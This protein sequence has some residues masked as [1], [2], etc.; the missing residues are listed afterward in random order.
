MEVGALSTG[1]R[2][3]VPVSC[4]GQQAWS[5]MEECGDALTNVPEKSILTEEEFDT[6]KAEATAKNEAVLLQL[7]SEAC[8]RCPAFSTAISE[9]KDTH[10]FRWVYGDAHATDTELPEL[11]SVTQLPA[12]I[13]Y[14]PGAIEPLVVPN[15]SPDQLTEHVYRHCYP[16]FTTDADF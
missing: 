3:V 14:T 11:F 6:L 2:E 9:L 10:V 12:L 5:S 13:L 7:G 1:V 8:T 15:A 16:V 4:G